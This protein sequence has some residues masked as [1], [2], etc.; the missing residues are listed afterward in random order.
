MASLNKAKTAAKKVAKGSSPLQ[1][2]TK[3]MVVGHEGATSHALKAKSELFLACVSG[4]AG[5]KSFYNDDRSQRIID[6]TAKVTKKDPTWV[7]NFASWLR[8]PEA[9]IRTA[10]LLVAAEYV[11]A[12]G[13]NG[14]Q[15]VSSVCQRADEPAELL[16]YW[17]DNHQGKRAGKA[18]AIPQSMRKGLADAA[19]RLYNEYSVLKYN[20]S[21]KQV[22]MADVLNL[23][24]AKPK[25]EGQGR[26]FKYIIDRSYGNELDLSGLD[27]IRANAELKAAA[28]LQLEN[29]TEERL[30][31]AGMTWEQVGSL[32]P[33]PGWTAKAWEAI[34]PNMGYMALLRNLRN[35]EEKGIS[36]ASQRYV[37]DYL[38]DPEKVA[39]SRQLPF[40]FLTAYKNVG[41]AKFVGAIEQALDL[42]VKN[43]PSFDGRTLVLVD[44]SGSM[45]AP[46][47]GT[48]LGR[49]GNFTSCAEAA[50]M[51]GVALRLKGE[52]VDVVAFGTKSSPVTFKK[53]SSVLTGIENVIETQVGWGTNLQD[54][55]M[56]HYD[57]H[58]R[59]VVLS[60]M[61]THHYAG[62]NPDVP[63][64]HYFD[65]RG[66]GNVGADINSPGRFLYGGLTDSTFKL[67]LQIEAGTQGN[68][69]WE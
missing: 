69:P 5:E 27:M 21:G 9:N 68:W 13:P 56:R 6:L 53:G 49:S 55:I 3:K 47:G 25:D 14:R 11:A 45:G 4:F 63:F 66:Y 29:L 22:S 31:A 15:V 44:T 17:I 48:P 12:G 62:E 59:I 51:F 50:S 30:K 42:S 10:S 2:K 36:A 1:A 57:G 64:I 41:S 18:P 16:A 28:P 65:L 37:N 43:I 19:R 34:I 26:L 24:H 46:V 33:H 40:R 38:S 61:Q 32:L 35:F 23:T 7:E 20:G 58:D 52:D 8:G 39:K 67:M 60:D 54:A